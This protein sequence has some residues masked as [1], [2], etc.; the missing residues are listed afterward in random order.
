M[1]ANGL[2][3]TYVGVGTCS[4]TASVA[5]GVN[6]LGRPAPPR[7][8]ACRRAAHRLDPV[9]L[10]PAGAGV[11]GG[12]FTAVVS[13]TGDGVTSVASNRGA[14]CTVGANGPTVTYVGVG[15]CSLT[16]SVATG[17]NY[18]GATGTAQT[19]SVS[20]SPP[21][22]STP[23]ISN[24]PGAG[25][26]GGSFTAVVSTTGDGVTSVAS[27]SGA[28]C[29]VGANGLTVTYVG[30]GTCSLTASVATGVNYLGATGTAQTF[31][32]SA[33][34]PTASTPSISNLPAPA[35]W[36]AASPRSCRPPVTA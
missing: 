3:V 9:D 35:W 36:A 34:P 33:S 1:G 16:A 11:V 15:T 32:V 20:A 4:L 21:T 29:T 10:E 17:V 8:S 12:S 5:T 14:V 13:T 28:V 25:V 6:Y 30:V 31:S 22:A 2:T 7:P 18:L 26:V 24:L 19:F 27:N 23:S